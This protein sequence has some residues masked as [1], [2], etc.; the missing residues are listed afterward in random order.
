MGQK[1]SREED[2]CRASKEHRLALAAPSECLKLTG[3]PCLLPS[4]GC[5]PPASISL[6]MT[7]SARCTAL[8]YLRV[9]VL[10]S[11]EFTGQ[12]Y[13]Q[14]KL[15]LFP[16]SQ[17]ASFTVTCYLA[18]CHSVRQQKSVEETATILRNKPC[19]AKKPKQKHPEINY[20]SMLL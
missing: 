16:L 6:D 9:Q 5:G 18:G 15:L 13:Q 1:G 11:P 3:G 17:T 2:E 7:Q 14:T 8:K 4:L 10:W 19:I 20:L 12:Y